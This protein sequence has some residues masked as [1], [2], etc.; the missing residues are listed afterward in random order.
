MIRHHLRLPTVIACVVSAALGAG[1]VSTRVVKGG[2][3]P[4]AGREPTAAKVQPA[5]SLALG[6]N[7]SGALRVV[8]DRVAADPIVNLRVAFLAGSAADPAGKEG[9]TALTARLMTEATADLDA[10]ALADALFPMAAELSV[11]VDKDA[12]VFIG[13]V[14][15]DHETAFLKILGDVLTRPRLDA[16]DFARL[17]DD[18]RNQLTSTLR[19]GNDEQLVREGL[20]ALIFDGDRTLGRTTSAARHP[21]GWTTAGTV[22]GLTAI[23]LD[24]VKA[25][26][27]AVFTVDRAVVG[28]GGGA[29]DALV[30]Q[31]KSIVSTLPTHSA[32]IAPASPPSP[33]AKSQLLIVEKPSAGTAI[34]VGFAVPSLSRAHPDWAAMK[35]AETYFGE[36]RNLIGHLF[37]S[38]REVRGLNYGDYAYVEHFV[39]QPGGTLERLNILRRTQYFSMWIRPVQHQTRLFAL[40]MAGWELQRF[41]DQ[42][43]PTD[44][45]LKRVRGFVAGYWKSKAQEPMRRLGYAMDATIVGA[46]T[47]PTSLLKAI[48]GLSRDDVN[49]AIRRHLRADRLSWVVVTQD[50]APLVEELTKGTPA[51]MTYAGAV[52]PEV[53]EEDK[54]IVGFDTG[55]AANSIVVVPPTALF[56]R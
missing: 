46:Q 53:L 3:D 24:D 10:A 48:E 36:H 44:D 25:W 38:M 41:V 30:G 40:R 29:S 45:D 17:R 51:V 28:V 16:A 21:Y 1:C 19:T 5:S 39:E 43:I 7:P 23:T 8:E 37:H 32:P 35:L 12:T 20:E 2:P 4:R 47:D 18:Q 52:G 13:R 9:L 54:G 56:E 26:R 34:S 14:H 6:P 31:L 42:G 22:A 27:E 55:L 15:K 11:Q 33:P 50:A 49:A